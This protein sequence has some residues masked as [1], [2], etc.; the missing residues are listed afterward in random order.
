[1]VLNSDNSL[2]GIPKEGFGFSD[3]YHSTLKRPKFDD[4]KFTVN[5]DQTKR[6]LV[7]IKY[8]L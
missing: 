2:I 8:M 3:Y 6:I 5:E 7:K 1:M 4:F